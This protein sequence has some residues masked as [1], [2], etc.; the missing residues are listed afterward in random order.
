VASLPSPVFLDKLK[1]TLYSF[2]PL[3]IPARVIK[4]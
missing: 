3:A 2:Y 4:P 1:T